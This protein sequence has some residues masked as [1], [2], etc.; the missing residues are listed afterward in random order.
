VTTGNLI[1]VAI[2]QFQN[3][4]TSISDNLGNTYIEAT[5]SRHANS[6][7]D[8]VQLYYAKNIS[9]GAATITIN[10]AGTTDSN[11][12]VYEYS[13]LNSTSPLDQVTSGTGSGSSPNGGVLYT[14]LD[15]EL[16]FV[17]GV[18]DYGLNNAPTPGSGYTLE[19]HQD[20]S[21]N[22]ERFYTQDKITNQG[23]INTNLTIGTGSNWA[24][25]GASFK[26]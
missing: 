20:D 2:T 8:Y 19:H 11:I 5:A 23:S 10:F 25:I 3:A 18:D 4:L 21:T 14:T 9:G 16:Y 26:P 12:G 15:N 6:S 13:G 24:I 7:S 17:V 1:V 22:H